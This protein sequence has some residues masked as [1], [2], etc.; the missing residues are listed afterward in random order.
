MA[1]FPLACLGLAVVGLLATS[2]TALAEEQHG[3]A[4]APKVEARKEGHDAMPA[5]SKGVSVG[6]IASL[7][8]GRLILAT[9]DG[10]LLFMPNWT[11]GMPKDGGGFDKETLARLEH[12]KAGDKVSIAWTW[13]E[14]RR[15]DTI[16]AAK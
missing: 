16:D 15:I 13:S 11:G 5:G 4:P 6:V 9:A 14:R 12:F 7:E 2:S 1:K 3:D 8:K 10:N